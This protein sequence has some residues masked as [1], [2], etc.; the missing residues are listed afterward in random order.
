MFLTVAVSLIVLAIDHASPAAISLAN[1]GQ[2]EHGLASS[3]TEQNPQQNAVTA[4]VGE[5]YKKIL[6]R[7]KKPENSKAYMKLFEQCVLKRLKQVS[8]ECFYAS[9]QHFTFTAELWA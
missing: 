7:R 1:Y 4:S 6:F 9:R 2:S 5:C 3:G 8:F